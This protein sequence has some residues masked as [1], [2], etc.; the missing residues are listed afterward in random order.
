MGKA[1]KGATTINQAKSVELLSP[2]KDKNG[3]IA[4]NGNSGRRDDIH[5]LF[6]PLNHLSSS[7]Y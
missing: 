5:F 4:K 3:T 2:C 6:H 7:E 1:T